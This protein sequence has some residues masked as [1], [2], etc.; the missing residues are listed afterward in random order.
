MCG[1][2][3]RHLPWQSLNFLPEPHG[4]GALRGVFDHSSLTTV[5]CFGTC[6]WRRAARAPAALLGRAAAVCS[7]S[8]R[9]AAGAAAAA[10]ANPDMRFVSEDDCWRLLTVVGVGARAGAAG[11]AGAAAA[12]GA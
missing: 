11:A 4:Q 5:S 7:T 8:S 1:S 12:A 10:A 3:R 6:G 2:T 9:S